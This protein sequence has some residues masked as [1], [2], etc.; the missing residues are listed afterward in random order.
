MT[1]QAITF[2]DSIFRR[3]GDVR[4]AHSQ[5]HLLSKTT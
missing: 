3:E 5:R 1:A 4:S 2:L